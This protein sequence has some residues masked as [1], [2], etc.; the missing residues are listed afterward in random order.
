MFLY[1]LINIWKVKQNWL[2]KMLSHPAG[3]AH[4]RVFI[5]K[6]FSSDLGVIPAKSSEIPPRRSGSLL[7][8][9]HIFC[10]SFLRKVTSY[11]GEPA[12]L[13]GPAHLHRLHFLLLNENI[14]SKWPEST[15]YVFKQI[16]M[17][18]L[19]E[20]VFLLRNCSKKLFRQESW[21]KC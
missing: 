3:L 1:Y 21:T 18:L 19:N 15:R 6:I 16:P 8:W 13:T 9:I 7:I 4:L 20:K 11:L 2:K 17:T 12:R 5:W 10:K 14:G